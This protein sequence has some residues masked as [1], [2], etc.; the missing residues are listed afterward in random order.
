MSESV[1]TL[2]FVAVAALAV[3]GALLI[4]RGSDVDDLQELVGQTLNRDFEVD[5]PKRLRII[6]FDRATA[7][8][9]EFEVAEVD[10]VWSLPSK[11]NYPADATEQMAAAATSV[12]NRKILR[13]A[14]DS[15]QAHAKYGVVDPL[16]PKLDAKSEGVGT[17]VIMT[18]A[19]DQELVDMIIGKRVA[20]SQGQRY[21]RNSRQNVVYVVELDP[22]KLTTDFADWI[23]DD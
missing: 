7:S 12:M 19:D 2:C 21:V 1:K 6:K 23:K 22:E 20:G 18:D 10:G 16:A 17:R 3:T 9:R 8:L 14:D 11:Q 15:A 5:Q 4:D 13:I